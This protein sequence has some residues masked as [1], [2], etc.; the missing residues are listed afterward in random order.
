M[1]GEPLYTLTIFTDYLGM[2]LTL[3]L[4]IYLLARSTTN[5]I[6]F[7]AVIALLALTFYYNFTITNIVNPDANNAAVRSLVI[8]IALAATHDLTHYLLPTELRGK[9]YW[10]ARGF[11]LLAIILFVL[12]FNMPTS[13]YCDPLY[14]CPIDITSPW[15]LIGLFLII[16]FIAILYNTWKI[17]KTG[18]WFHTNSIYLALILGTSTI[19]YGFMG[20][21]LNVDL[22]RFVSTYL[23][24]GSLVLLGYSVTRHQTLITRRTTYFDLPITMVTILVVLIIYVFAAWRI[25]LSMV[26]LVF[27]TVLAIFTHSMYDFVREFLDRS[28]RR[29]DRTIKR[30]IRS[31]ARNGS[32]NP[33]LTSYMKRVLV[34][35]CSN[36]Q[37]SN[38]FIALK[39]DNKYI[40]TTTYQ[41]L[42]TSTEIPTSD[43]EHEEIKQP[44]GRLLEGTSRV[45]PVF[46]GGE[47]VAAIGIGGRSGLPTYSESDLYWLE[48]IADQLG[49]LI[50]AHQGLKSESVMDRASPPQTD[51]SQIYQTLENEELM[52][53]LAYRPDPKLVKHVEEGLRNLHDYSKLGKSPLV[54]LFNAEGKSHIE[55]G[56]NIKDKIIGAVETLKPSGELPS[57]PL[58][59]E[60][61]SYTILND[62]YVLDEPSRE[63]MAKL[64]I[65]EGTYYRTR[66]KALRGVTR[67]LLE[68]ETIS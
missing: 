10:V 1:E 20:T 60:W 38:G 44:S 22:P 33:S 64:Y 62:A 34:I 12:L 45:A 28:L 26:N 46:G 16:V 17:K 61:H 40:V 13:G 23:I 25:G 37:S 18:S 63:I 42:P 11:I 50:F 57:E 8:I 55:R 67:T 35:L 27:L 58:P 47:Q 21:I 30:E 68:M 39:Q 19:A 41:S 14:I 6:T 15:V 59:R 66:R 43:V 53:A 36:L 52:T 49:S 5:H 7:R 51:I 3:W 65:S 54:A 24:L 56:K 29:R 32:T 9:L 4:A 48:D 2:V 31:L